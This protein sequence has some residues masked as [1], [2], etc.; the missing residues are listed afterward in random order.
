MKRW[1]C[2]DNVA[3]VSVADWQQA[4]IRGILIDLDNTLVSEDD[5]WLSPGVEDWL[6]RSREAG[7]ALF[8]LSNGRR[9]QRFQYWSQRLGV[10]GI[11]RAQKPLPRGFRRAQA[12]LGLGPQALL[13]IGDSLHTDGLG[14]WLAGCVWIQV[15]SLP[16]PPRWWEL[17]LGRWLHRPYPRPEELIPLEPQNLTDLPS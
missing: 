5:R 3:A 7:L 1:Q 15:C 12:S 17:W 13:V 8:L 9:V 14:A 2:L 11:C 4:G 16:H 10:P 6:R